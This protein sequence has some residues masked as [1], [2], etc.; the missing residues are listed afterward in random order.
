M[1]TLHTGHR[2]IPQG[3]LLNLSRC[4]SQARRAQQSQGTVAPLNGKGEGKW[5]GELWLQVACGP[6]RARPI[7][8]HHGNQ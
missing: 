1:T 3:L 8:G 6:G 5:I 2:K 7:P 4:S